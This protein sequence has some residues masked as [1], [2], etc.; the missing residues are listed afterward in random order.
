MIH[1]ITNNK[2]QNIDKLLE[3]STEIR[4]KQEVIRKNE[5]QH[6]VDLSLESPPHFYKHP[7]TVNDHYLN[8]E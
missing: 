2:K 3:S 5:I 1:Q 8:V 4:N 7:W 6:M